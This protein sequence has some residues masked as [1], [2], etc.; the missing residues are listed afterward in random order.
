M[1]LLQQMIVLFVLMLIGF[2]V[3]KKG[4]ISDATFKQMSWLVVYVACPAMVIS[5]SVNSGKMMEGQELFAAMGLTLAIYAVL[6][7]LGLITP[8]ILGVPKEDRGV[9]KVMMIF[10]NIGFMGFPLIG[11]LYGA[12]ALLYAALFQIPFNVLIYTYGIL[13]LKKKTDDNEKLDL[14]K[15]FNIGVI[16]CIISIV[17]ALF[18]I[19]TPDF[20]KTIVS[21]L[22]NLT[23]PLSMMVIGASLT[24]I[25]F[26]DLFTDIRLLLFCGL[27]LIVIPVVM[28][29]VLKQ[30][31]DN[32]MVLGVCMVILSTPVASMTAMLAQQ[33]DGNYPLASKGVA[34]ST[35]LSVLTMPLVAMITGL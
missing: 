22:S 7:F 9:Y 31:I 14:K 5:G 29:F 2:F 35:I 24:K 15:I 33:Y 13:V 17:I 1:L 25:R 16:C 21:N 3:S 18:Q 10:S 23:A 4:Y 11:S 27:K 20:V 26:K 30:F 28:L 32:T 19:E 8:F 6:I 12:E 34:V